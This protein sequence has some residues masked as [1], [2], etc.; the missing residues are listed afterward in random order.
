[1]HCKAEKGV[2]V[3]TTL[4]V[5]RLDG[6]CMTNSVAPKTNIARRV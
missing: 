1:M 6:A 4:A 3:D 2:A 5:S